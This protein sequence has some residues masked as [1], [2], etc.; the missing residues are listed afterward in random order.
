MISDKFSEKYRPKTLEQV[1]LPKRIRDEIGDGVL[2]QDFLFYSTKP[3]TGKTTL[4]KALA[5]KYNALYIN[6]SDESSVEVLR[7]KVTNFAESISLTDTGEYMIKVVVLDEIDGASNQFYAALRGMMQDMVNVRFIATC[8][9]IDKLPEPIMD[10]RFLPICFEPQGEEETKE[11]I[12]GYVKRLMGIMKLNDITIE[13]QVAV[14]FVRKNFPDMRKMLNKVQSFSK[15]GLTKVTLEDFNTL[16]Y[17]YGDIFEI[18]ISKPDPLANYEYIMGKYSGKCDDVLYSLGDEFVQW[19]KDK[20]EPKFLKR[21]PQI[22]EIVA[23]YQYK[24]NFAIDKNI[25]TMACVF[26]IQNLFDSE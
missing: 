16:N 2:E 20:N 5:R 7:G 22:Q 8:N 26:A 9:Y 21:L 1:V 13:P 18:C 3:G 24:R 10:S 4:A 14:K 6:V 19:L 15:K 11:V 12:T 23:E 17:N 25:I